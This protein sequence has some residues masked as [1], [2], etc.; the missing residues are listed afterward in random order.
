MT[1][2]TCF[3]LALAAALGAC[4]RPAAAWS[5][6]AFD[7]AVGQSFG[8]DGTPHEGGL[9]VAFSPLWRA[10]DHARFGATVFADDIGNQTEELFDRSRSDLGSPELGTVVSLH[11][12]TWGL[13]WRGDWDVLRRGR[14]TGSLSGLGGWWRVQDDVRGT[15]LDAASA[16]GYA[17]GAS[18]R[19][20]VTGRHEV[21]VTLR[22]QQLTS[23]RHANY[24]RVDHYATAALD[25]R[26]SLETDQ[27]AR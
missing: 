16:V 7:L 12:M 23:D 15:N 6:P 26:W 17:L 13:A 2:T 4:A 22:W 9:A 10:G 14:W 11:R 21:G 1:R 18:A 27:D 24:R 3:A 8:I 20:Q 19:R 25:W 5:V